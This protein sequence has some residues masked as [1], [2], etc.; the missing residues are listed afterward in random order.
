[1][2]QFIDDNP[3]NYDTTLRGAYPDMEQVLSRSLDLTVLLE[4]L[5]FTGVALISL[6]ILW[7]GAKMIMRS[8]KGH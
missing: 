7:T 1:M 5:L 3:V 6:Y 8:F 4:T 2:S